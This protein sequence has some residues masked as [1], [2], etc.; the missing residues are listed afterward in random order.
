MMSRVAVVTGGNKGIGFAIV[1]GLCEQFDGIVYLT[2]RNEAKGQAAVEELKKLG[3]QP[4]F[5]QLDVTDDSSVDTFKQYISDIHGGLDVLVNNAAIAFK[6]NSLDP[7]SYQASE[8]IKVNYFGLVRVCKALF[9]L[10]RDHA[11]VVNLSSSA[12]HLSRIQGDELKA[13]LA[14]LTLT[15]DDLSQIMRD[16]IN[17]AQTNTH[18]ELGWA[19]NVYSA[20][21]VAVS[22]LTRIQQRAFDEDARKDIAVNSVHPGL[23]ETDMTSHRAHLT[24]ERGARAPLYLA[25]L[26]KNTNIKG[27]Y[28]WHNNIIVDW[29]NDPLPGPY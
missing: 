20:S 21:K 9:P 29:I 1:K 23:V 12:G 27:K 13:R 28:V 18:R 4:R 26:T 8:T 24:P 11:R 16:L 15:E 7:F 5:H 17:A 14:S 10:L 22:A 2:A 25:F 3:L 19:N 6:H